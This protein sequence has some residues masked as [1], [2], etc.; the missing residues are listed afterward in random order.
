MWIKLGREGLKHYF[1]ALEA[2]LMSLRHRVARLER[3]AGA[4]P[5]VERIE[6]ERRPKRLVAK[7]VEQTPV[8][9]MGHLEAYRVDEFC[10]A[11]GISR[12]TYNK[13]RTDGRGP[14]EMRVGKS[15][16]ISKEAAL[17]WER[18]RQTAL[19]P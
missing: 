5:D 12:S 18:A 19:K 9:V 6:Q 1:D 3:A 13:L 17:D 14:R 15:I 7:A 16:R 4:P 2:E 8:P 10:D 11:Y